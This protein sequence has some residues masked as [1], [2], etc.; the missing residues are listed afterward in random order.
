MDHRNRLLHY[1]RGQEDLPDTAPPPSVGPPLTTERNP[2]QLFMPVEL[3][4]QLINES[5]RAIGENRAELD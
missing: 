4:R 5:L 3:L 2:L 1:A